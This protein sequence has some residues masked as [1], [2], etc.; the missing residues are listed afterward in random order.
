[1]QRWG[2]RSRV[3]LE[4]ED[5]DEGQRRKS[6]SIRAM[7]H[8]EQEWNGTASPCFLVFACRLRTHTHGAVGGDEGKSVS[9]AMTPGQTFLL[10][11]MFQLSTRS[12]G[13]G[14]LLWP[15]PRCHSP[16]LLLLECVL[17]SCY[18]T[19]YRSESKQERIHAISEVR[20]KGGL[21]QV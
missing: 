3:R 2:V 10:L 21:M 7:H 12:G 15:T 14:C 11:R 19:L 6:V 16:S 17:T 13:H 4:F 9:L 8:P 1:M 5:S 20:S 18:A